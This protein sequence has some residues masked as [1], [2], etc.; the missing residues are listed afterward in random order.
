MHLKSSCSLDNPLGFI[1]RL[2]PVQ[3]R[4]AEVL[5]DSTRSKKSEKS[6]LLHDV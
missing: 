4:Q 2:I 3:K 6:P 1:V 5:L